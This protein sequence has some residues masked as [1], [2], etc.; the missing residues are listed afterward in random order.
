LLAFWVRERLE[1]DGI[2][3]AK[4]CGVSAN[5]ETEGNNRK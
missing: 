5:A 1:Q 4:H 2:D 3:D